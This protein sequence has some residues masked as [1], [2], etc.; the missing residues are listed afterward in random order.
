M[1]RRQLLFVIGAGVV[2]GLAGCTSYF[3]EGIQ[4]G[5]VTATNSSSERRTIE[6]RVN[7]ND[8]IV[9]QDS[10]D[11]Q[12]LEYETMEC[13]WEADPGDFLVEAKFG[14]ESEW[15]RWDVT[16]YDSGCV[17]LTAVVDPASDTLMRTVQ[18]DDDPNGNPCDC[19]AD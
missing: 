12:P 16:D 8:E 5:R 6:M 18:L 15:R 13:A 19:E 10:F 2:T 4:L 7:R 9:A 14:D 3:D 11:L 1:K 17:S